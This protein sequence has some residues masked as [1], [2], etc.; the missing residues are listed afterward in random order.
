M[1]ELEPEPEPEELTHSP[2]EQDE[3]QGAGHQARVPGPLGLV[4]RRNAQEDEDDGLSNAGQCLHR[5]LHCGP[6]LLRDVGLYVLV[7]PD[8]AEGHPA[9]VMAV[10]RVRAEAV[11]IERRDSRQDGGQREELSGQVGQ[12][13]QQK[14]EERLDDADLLGEAG[15]E[16]EDDGKD[17][18]HQSPPDADDEEGGCGGQQRSE[19]SRGC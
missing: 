17:Q 3:D 10:T 16:T 9:E 11:Q 13:D 2:E 12:V 7:G 18:T 19:V 4:H 5:V 14:D 8:A 6:G 15:D 1:S